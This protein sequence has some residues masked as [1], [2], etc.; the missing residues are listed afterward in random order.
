MSTTKPISKIEAARG[1][2]LALIPG[3]PINGDIAREEISICPRVEFLRDIA[4][5]VR[6]SRHRGVPAEIIAFNVAH[7]LFQWRDAGVHP[8][9]FGYA[10]RA[11]ASEE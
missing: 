6:I 5:Y 7:D 8:R 9:T 10:R 3:L 2:L 11:S 4:A 1:E